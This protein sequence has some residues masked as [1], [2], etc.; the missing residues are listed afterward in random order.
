[1]L[2]VGLTGNIGSGKSI[3][4]QVFE[5][6]GVPV[7]H[8]DDKAKYILD[9]P[10]TRVELQNLFGSAI[11]DPSGKTDRKKIAEIVFNNSAKL[12]ALNNIIHPSV[13]KDF[14]TWI[15]QQQSASYVIME[16]AILFETGY[17]DLFDKIIVVTAPE[18]IRIDRVMKRDK[19]K[20]E[21]IIKRIQNQM[22]EADKT[23]KADFL[24]VNDNGQLVIPQVLKIHQLFSMRMV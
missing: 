2:K 19:I 15:L 22:P 18:N 10:E 8:S 12:A 13:I 6:L 20:E 11:F 16:S 17:A 3:V 9:E 4:S 23:A 14:Q 1:M 24:I 7:Y 21:E 5:T